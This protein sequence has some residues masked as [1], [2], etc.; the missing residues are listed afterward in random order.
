MKIYAIARQTVNKP[1]LI[2]CPP[3]TLALILP[4][5]VTESPPAFL[6]LGPSWRRLLGSYP[7]EFCLAGFG[8][9]SPPADKERDDNALSTDLALLQE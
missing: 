1:Q 2:K 6:N 8:G 3:L 9:T 4:F 5:S 7:N